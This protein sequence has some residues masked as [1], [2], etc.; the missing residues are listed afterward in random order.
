MFLFE[1]DTRVLSLSS[2]SAQTKVLLNKYCILCC[3]CERLGPY[4]RTHPFA[5]FFN[6]R[7]SMLADRAT[8]GNRNSAYLLKAFNTAL[9][10]LSETNEN[11][12]GQAYLSV[13]VVRRTSDNLRHWF[14]FISLF[15]PLYDNFLHKC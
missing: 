5:N 6:F 11:Q 13:T 12:T 3:V 4:F 1:V 8:C 14:H 15:V 2:L 9:V 10:R 7:N